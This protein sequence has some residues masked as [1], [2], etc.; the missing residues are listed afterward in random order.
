MVSVKGFKKS[1]Q[2]IGIDSLED[3]LIINIIN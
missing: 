1:L 2:I 3:I